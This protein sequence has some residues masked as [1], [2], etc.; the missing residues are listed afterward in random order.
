[1]LDVFREMETLR[2]EMDRL[3]AG[4]TAVPRRA[5]FLPGRAAGQYPLINTRQ[6]HDNLYVEAL[7]PGVD[8]K[9]LDVAV[10]RNTLTISGEKPR[11]P[12]GTPDV[13]E[14]AYHRSE[15]AAGRF[16]RSL[17]LPV[18][19]DDQR[20]GARYEHGVLHITLPKSESAK[21]R[22]ITVAVAA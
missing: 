8:P 3:F 11:R 15:R 2:R 22:R 10:V 5:A 20:V 7:M 19:V 18:E 9:T 21:P 1:M 14:E 17:G 13:T 6:D 12:A 16:S 4:A